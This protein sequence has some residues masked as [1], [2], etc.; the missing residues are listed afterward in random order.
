[1]LKDIPRGLVLGLTGFV[2]RAEG[3]CFLT[4]SGWRKT[5]VLNFS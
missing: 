5:L 2:V 4:P 3:K 1:M